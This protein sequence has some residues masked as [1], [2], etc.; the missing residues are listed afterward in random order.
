MTRFGEAVALA[1]AEN[2]TLPAE[3]IERAEK[4]SA[5]KNMTFTPVLGTALLAKATDDSIDALSLREDA[6]HKGYS[7]RSLAKEV[8]VPCCVRAGIDL[9]NKGAEPLNNQP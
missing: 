2:W 5:A 1:L 3:W 7:A 6:G 9:R 8:L 4:V